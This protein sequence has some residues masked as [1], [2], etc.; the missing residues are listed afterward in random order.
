MTYNLKGRETGSTCLVFGLVIK[1]VLSVRN[2]APGREMWSNNILHR[3]CM[4]RENKGSYT[5]TY[6]RHDASSSL[7]SKLREVIASAVS[8]CTSVVL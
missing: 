4:E 6:C 3:S 8:I 1:Q 2:D 7:R 5:V